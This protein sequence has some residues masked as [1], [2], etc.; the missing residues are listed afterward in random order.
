VRILYGVVGEGMGHAMRSAVLLER[1]AASGHDVRIVVSGRAADYLE[2]RHP[3]KVTKI[4]GLTMIYEDNTV[5]KI[6]T[7]LANLKSLIDVPDNF[8]SYLEM[9]RTFSP[10]VVISDF[11]SWTYWFAKGQRIPIISVDNMQIIP[12]CHHE[13][14]VLGDEM[15]SFLLA[16]SIVRAK[17]P[18]CNAYLITTF[19]YPRVKRDRTTLHPPIL[20]DVI[21]DAKANVK[22]GEHV[23]VYQ[24]GT[25]HDTLLDV[26]KT[27]DVPFRIYGMKR[28]I[29]AEERDANLVHC[30]FSETKFIDDLATAKCVIAGGGFTLM[31]EA[32]YLGKP[33]LSVPLVGQFEQVLNANYLGK[34]GYGERAKE[35]TS[36]GLKRF[37]SRAPEYTENLKRFEH[38]RNEGLFKE[39]EKAMKA[40]IAEGARGTP[41]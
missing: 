4:T 24:S 28:G 10:D 13:E 16:K 39:L 30:P 29:T 9:A 23:L 40:A 15:K 19:F 38:D 36:D 26:L 6:K 22:A 8:R 18:R 2:K 25:S 32:I 20:R 7:A 27:A 34:L 31:G 37:L 21:L 1:L 35:V 3:G 17:L 11:E 5:Q 33:M 14:D 12:R 41:D